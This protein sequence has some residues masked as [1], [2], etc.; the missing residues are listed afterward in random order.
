[1]TKEIQRAGIPVVHVT[2][3]TKI[4]EGI[5][6]NRILR[7]NSVLHVFGNPSL[8]HEKEVDYRREMVEK[9]LSLLEQSP[10]D[11]TRAVVS[12]E[13]RIYDGTVNLRKLP[14]PLRPA[15]LFN[16][17]PQLRRAAKCLAFARPPPRPWLHFCRR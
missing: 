15:E 14:G 1:M 13:R 7:G 17:R 2:N 5:G 16:L 4:S 6:A 8:P 10:H 3:L 9:A 12:E 11:G